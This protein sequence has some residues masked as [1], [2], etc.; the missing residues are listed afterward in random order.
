VKL[1]WIVV[2]S[3]GTLAVPASPA[4]AQCDPSY[5]SCSPSPNKETKP[6]TTTKPDRSKATRPKID[7]KKKSDADGGNV[8][9][10]S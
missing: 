10:V 3:V 7:K 1:Y 9:T 8:K 2:L 4:V 6:S 5:Q